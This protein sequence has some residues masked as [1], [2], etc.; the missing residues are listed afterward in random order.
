MKMQA[1]RLLCLLLAV[2]LLCGCTP[3]GAGNSA[4][5]AP[6]TSGAVAESEAP[7]GAVETERA[8]AQIRELG[9]SPDDNY[10]V[11]YEVFL[12]SFCDSDGD[13]IGDLRGLISKLDYL[14]ELGVGG[15]WLMPIHPSTTYHKYNVADYYAVDP[16]Y[17]TLDDFRA[18]LDGCRERNIRVILDL[19]VN[20]TGSDHP[21]FTQ[22]ADYLRQLGA[23][24]SDA[25]ACPYVAYYN[26][27]KEFRTGYTR[28]SGTD[29][30]YESRFSPDMPDLNW[31]CDALREEVRNIMAYWLDMGVS[32][33]RVDAAKEFYSGS[34]EQNVA[35]LSWL[36]S[37]LSALKPDGY[38]VAEVWDSFDQVARYYGSGV[39]SIF[40]Y[41][42]GDSSGKIMKVLRGAGQEKVVSSFAEAL[43]K[44]DGAYLAAN[45]AYIDAPFLSNHDV[46]RIAGFCGGDIGKIKL[47]AAM[48]LFM[49]GSAFVYYGEEIGMTGSGNDP[50]KRAPMYWNAARDSG[51]T[52][53]PPECVLPEN[54]PFAPAEEQRLDDDSIYNYYRRLIAIR[55]ALPVISH[56]RTTAE[57]ALNRGSVSA[58]RKT[59]G[60]ETCVILLNVS[61]EETTAALQGYE[62]WTAAAALSADGTPVT[63]NGT[64]LTLPPYAAAVLL[65]PKS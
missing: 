7:A 62:G 29:W 20:H 23:G 53:P 47:A 17:G 36:Q 28:I 15:L 19:V 37:T 13:G 65:P 31:D 12:Y 39:T 35:V 56:G 46:G 16:A 64:A 32:G 11:W 48:N 2:L 10:R 9:E 51:T 42:F 60:E 4:S 6:E 61:P 55:N 25:A 1:K 18:L 41:P 49:S 63:Q 54:Y 43:E 27:T 8:L 40:A 24:E 33:F 3:V 57:T 44:A 5:A 30:Y 26:F 52:Q 21:W 50:S 34:T 22:A 59:W 14:Q 38:M 58:F 45:P